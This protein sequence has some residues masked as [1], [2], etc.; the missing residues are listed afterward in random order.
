MP[1][2]SETRALEL[3]NAREASVLELAKQT[4]SDVTRCAVLANWI[5]GGP[6]KNADGLLL[7]PDPN[8]LPEGLEM[9]AGASQWAK[10]TE[11][12]SDVVQWAILKRE[13]TAY[14][15]FRGT[16]NPFDWTINT[17]VSTVPMTT[18]TWRGHHLIVHNGMLGGLKD[19][20]CSALSTLTE[21]LLD[22]GPESIVLCGHS[23][24]GG[25]A[26]IAAAELL[27]LVQPVTS[28]YTFGSPMVFAKKNHKLEHAIWQQLHEKT[29]A[30]VYNCDIVPRTLSKTAEN[31]IFELVRDYL[32]NASAVRSASAWVASAAWVFGY[33]QVDVRGMMTEQLNSLERNADTIYN[34]YPC[35]T[36]LFFSHQFK[37][38]REELAQEEG[39]EIYCNR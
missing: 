25:Y 33:G 7:K 11:G 8:D 22:L 18:V 17:G 4:G 10:P 3:A 38:Q 30:L 13:Q 23:L 36:L 15:V 5:Y 35:G 28:I 29:H 34:F 1:S 20:R 27:Q 19:D 9:V 26:M 2:A 6:G 12:G 24:G 37:D 16:Q 32:L 39:L 21:K 14:V 31:W